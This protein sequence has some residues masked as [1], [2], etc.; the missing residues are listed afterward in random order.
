MPLELYKLFNLDTR[1][2]G[3][4]GLAGVGIIVSG[5]GFFVGDCVGKG[6][7]GCVGEGVGVSVG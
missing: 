1:S 4:F 7:G 6:E 3:G 5:L 2:D